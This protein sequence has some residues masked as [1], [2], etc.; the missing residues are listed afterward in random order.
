MGFG[1]DG[2]ENAMKRGLVAFC[3]PGQGSLAV[4]MGREVAEA[5]PEALDV[6]E[7]SSAAAG[8]SHSF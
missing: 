2:M 5:V 8:R 4:G 1:V 3:L 6:F 7:R